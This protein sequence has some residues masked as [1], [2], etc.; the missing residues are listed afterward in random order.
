MER[1]E[2]ERKANDLLNQYN[3][4]ADNGVEIV[5][6]CKKTGFTLISVELD[7]TEDGFIIAN[8]TINSFPGFKTN[9]V[10]AVNSKRSY[11]EKRFI[12]AHE[13]GHYVLQK[14][15]HTLFAARDSRHGR[16]ENENDID[17]FAACLLMPK[18][19]FVRQYNRLEKETTTPVSDQIIIELA[20]VFGVPFLSVV[21]RMRETGLINEK[22]S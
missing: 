20:D 16:S 14:E 1:N 19:A 9:K 7:D 2:I 10:I 12:I 3:I 11:E 6:L 5:N 4:N 18:D 15:G 21:R 17:F 13:L 22:N 8:E